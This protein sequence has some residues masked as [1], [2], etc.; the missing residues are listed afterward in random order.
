MKIKYGPSRRL[1]RTVMVWALGNACFCSFSLDVLNLLKIP[2][3][4]H[5]LLPFNFKGT[6]YYRHYHIID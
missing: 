4:L 3:S 6:W 2:P 1:K 5:S